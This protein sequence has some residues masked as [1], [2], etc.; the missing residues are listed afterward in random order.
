MKKIIILNLLA[1]LILFSPLYILATP[2][3]TT[4]I[5]NIFSRIGGWLY[6]FLIAGAVIGIIIGAFTILLAG[7]DPGKVNAGKMIIIYALIAVLIG[8]FARGL[9]NAVRNLPV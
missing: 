6:S 1:F 5:D 7:G 9:V 3:N 2:V 8:V 4:A